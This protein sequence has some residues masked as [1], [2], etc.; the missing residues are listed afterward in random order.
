MSSQ[1]S[2]PQSPQPSRPKLWLTGASGFLG[3]YVA[4]ATQAQWDV[5]GTYHRHA[6]TL[7]GIVSR[8]LDLTD[9]IALRRFFSDLKPA[10]VIHTAALSQPNRCQENPVLSRAINVTASI[11]LADLCAEA[12]IPFV[13]TSSDQVFD[14]KHAPYRETDSVSPLNLYGEHKA[15]AEAEILRRHPQAAVCRMALMYGAAPTATNFLQ[16]F[17]TQIGQGKTLQLFTDEF[18]TPLSGRDAAAGLLLALEKTQGLLH[19]AGGD[20]LS[21]YEMGKTMVDVFNLPAASIQPSR[22]ADMPLPAPR[23]P[24]V[25]ADIGLARSLGFAPH[26]FRSELENLKQS[27]AFSALQITTT[28]LTQ[29]L[30][31]PK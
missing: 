2:Q 10:A 20:R 25:S 13:F 24:D 4:E 7:P 19:L 21:R 17:L 29:K 6:V 18:R 9:A 30:R 26:P 22:Q 1:P 23:P 8:A 12:G 14:G 28:G 11:Q 16:T 27:G 31:N 5:V 15:E 3:W